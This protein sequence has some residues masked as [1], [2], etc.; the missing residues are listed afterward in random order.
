MT[1]SARAISIVAAV[2]RPFVL[3]RLVLNVMSSR[4]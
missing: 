2:M 3:D 4:R 1:G